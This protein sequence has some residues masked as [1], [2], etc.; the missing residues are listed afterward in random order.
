MIELVTGKPG[1]GKSYYSVRAIH[2]AL[3]RGQLVATNVELSEGWAANMARANGFRR[4]IPGRVRKVEQRYARSVYVTADL[5]EI[6]RLRLAG[7]GRCKTC[8]AGKVCAKEGRG[9]LVLDEAHMWLNART[10]DQDDAGRGLGRDAAVRQRLA[11]VRLF[12]QHR[13][14][15]WNVVLITQDEANLDTQVRRNF[16][17][18]THLKNLR[19]FRVAGLVPL[20]PFNLF[21]AIRHW[22]DSAKSVVGRQVFTLNRRVARCYDTMATSHGLEPDAEDVIVLGGPATA[23]KR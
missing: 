2:Q 21:V 9:L 13:K 18:H 10:W 11:I 8:K 7:C 17:Y 12:T 23:A 20:V 6:G 15:G 14:L 19:R 22:H 5:A 4:L 16:E 3:E 1:A